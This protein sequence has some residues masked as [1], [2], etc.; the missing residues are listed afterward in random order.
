MDKEEL[1]KFWK[2]S[3]S[4]SRDFLKDSSSLRD[5]HF[6][7]IWLISLDKVIGPSQKFY[8]VTWNKEVPV[9]FWKSS[10]SE[11]W[12]WSSDPYSDMGSG[13]GRGCPWWR[14]AVSD[15]S[16]LEVNCVTVM[17]HVMML[18]RQGIR[19]GIER[20]QFDSQFC[21]AV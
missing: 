14:Y 17:S 2:S 6:S 21:I 9:K 8:D 13:S 15:C 5:G 18:E 19:L 7:T 12:I 16:C 11:F 10:R 1:I 4:R 3:A 20:S